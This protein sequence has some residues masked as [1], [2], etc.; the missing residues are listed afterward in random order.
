VSIEENIALRKAVEESMEWLEDGN[1]EHLDNPEFYKQIRAKLNLLESDYVLDQSVDATGKGAP[2]AYDPK[3]IGRK[4]MEFGK[5]QGRSI[6]EVPLDY[7][8]WLSDQSRTFAKELD[9]YLNSKR[10]LSERV[11][12]EAD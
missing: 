10:V 11:D 7:L 1:P 4:T 8:E 9:A 3:R 5:Y 2:A 6:D 12:D